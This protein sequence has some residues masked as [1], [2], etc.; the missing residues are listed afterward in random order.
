MIDRLPW[1]IFIIFVLQKYGIVNNFNGNCDE[2]SDQ[3]L[4]Y[5]TTHKIL[6]QNMGTLSFIQWPI[7]LTISY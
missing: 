2:K 3:M 6:H 7:T 4:V 1:N 5:T